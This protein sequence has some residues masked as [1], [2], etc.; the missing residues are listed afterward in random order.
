MIVPMMGNLM[1]RFGNGRHGVWISLGDTPRHKEGSRKVVASEHGEDARQADS[2]SILAL[3]AVQ[4][5]RLP[6]EPHAPEEVSV[7]IET[8]DGATAHAFGP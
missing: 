6:V 2:G 3:R 5:A 1:T 8:Q 7:E 4:Q